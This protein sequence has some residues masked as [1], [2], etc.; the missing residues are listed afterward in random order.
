[1]K[2][3][4]LLTTIFAFVFPICLM[5]IYKKK[6][7]VPFICF[8]VGALC[9][10][11]FV[12]VLESLVHFYFLSIN[13]STTIFINSSF[14]I[15]ALYAGLMAGIFEETGRLFAF[16]VFLKKYNDK[17]V[18]IA[19]GIGH[20]GMECILTLGI[21]YLMYAVFLFLGS[22]GD[23]ATDEMIVQIINGLDIS[24]IPYA[25]LERIIALIIHISLSIIMF[26]AC[27]NSKYFYLY[28]VSIVLHAFV[29]IP[30][31]LYQYGY[32][33]SL[34][35]TELM[36]LIITLIIMFVAIKIYKKKENEDVGI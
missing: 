29:D 32:I 21:T 28:P 22:T 8:V 30:A 35:T 17:K 19:Y 3:A 9:F 25:I 26:K 23:V 1:M 14:V 15:F 36:T 7:N 13:E 27:K 20:G 10:F 18:S 12:N 11:I 34:L 5:I 24:V 16:K 2:T 4:I 31:G 6:T 33:K